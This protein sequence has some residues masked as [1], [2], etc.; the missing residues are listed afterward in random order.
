[1]NWTM[2][3][4]KWGLKINLIEKIVLKTHK[5]RLISIEENISEQ[6]EE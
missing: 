2:K 3:A 1:M 4:K 5:G 6:A